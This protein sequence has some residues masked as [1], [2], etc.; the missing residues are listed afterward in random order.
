MTITKASTLEEQDDHQHGHH[1]KKKEQPS[2]GTLDEKK[3][4]TITKATTSK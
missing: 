1:I 2:L 4:T 3:N